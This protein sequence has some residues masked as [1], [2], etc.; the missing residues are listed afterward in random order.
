MQHDRPH[1]VHLFASFDLQDAAVRTGRI[2]SGLSCPCRHTIIALDRR[3]R[4]RDLIPADLDVG[5]IGGPPAG[6]TPWLRPFRLRR[7]LQLLQPDLMLTYGAGLQDGLLANQGRRPTLHLHHDENPEVR[8]RQ[9]LVDRAVQRR[10]RARLDA[11]ATPSAS[12]AERLRAEIR[13]ARPLVIHVPNGVTPATTAITR[14]VPGLRRQPGEAVLGTLSRF[15]ED[16]HLEQLILAFKDAA[17]GRAQLVVLGDGPD[18]AAV[19]ALVERLGLSVRVL[20]AGDL[21][22]PVPFLDQF[23]LF[24][25]NDAEAAVPII[26]LEAMAHALPLIGFG[27]IDL[28]DATSA[29]NRDFILPG[30]RHAA[31]LAR[32]DALLSS[33]QLRLQL[34]RANQARA[35]AFALEPMVGAYGDLYRRLLQADQPRGRA[36]LR[37]FGRLRDDA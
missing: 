21:G 30:G 17:H 5:V 36:P 34:G 29:P 35:A 32:L 15:R 33:G 19:T 11:L 37:A 2:I 6:P 13:G 27:R 3:V 7:L 8:P 20:L 23:D 25:V 10:L 16:R 18:H 22:D 26:A 31:L 14:S 24:A 1:L 9:G 4:A 28:R 12:L